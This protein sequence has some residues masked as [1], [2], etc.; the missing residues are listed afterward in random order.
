MVE[1]A[2]LLAHPVRL[3][4]MG[5]TGVTRTP[6]RPASPPSRPRSPVWLRAETGGA[7]QASPVFFRCWGAMAA[8]PPSP[9]AALV[10]PFSGVRRTAARS[11]CRGRR[12]EG[13]AAQGAIAEAEAEVA[14]QSPC[15]A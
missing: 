10:R 9:A 4:L 11:P 6:R 3:R 5:V 14:D 8:A 15:S 12:S 2:G 13:T 1:R 7:P